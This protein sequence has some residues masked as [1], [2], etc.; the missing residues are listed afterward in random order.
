M[1]LPSIF[2]KNFID[3]FFNDAFSFPFSFPKMNWM[4]TNVQDLGNEYLLEMEL[5]GFEKKDIH[6]QLNNGY[7]TITAEREESREGNDKKGRYIHR[8]RY[9]GSCKRSFYVGDYL[10]EEDFK[11]SFDN[12]VLKLVFPKDKKNPKL[13]DKR[14]IPIE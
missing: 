3:D 2:E 5:P 8:E 1:L 6:A 12:G 14:Y 4:S 10:K 9:S 7:L 11:A 13:E